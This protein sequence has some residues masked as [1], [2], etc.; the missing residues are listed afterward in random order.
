MI[1][2]LR[3][4][5]TPAE[6]GEL[7]AVPNDA[8]RWPEHRLRTELTVALARSYAGRRP[9][10]VVDLAAGNGHAAAEV[11][12]A[13]GRLYLGDY[14]GVEL[15]AVY[16]SAYGVEVLGAWRGPLEETLELVPDDAADV[17][18]LGE[19]LEHVDDPAAVLRRATVKAR[20]LVL[21]TPLDEPAGVNPEHLWR[22][23]AAGIRELLEAAAWRPTGSLLLELELP[24]APRFS[25]YRCQLW[26]AEAAR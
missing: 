23:D 18:L 2:R 17:M 6:L 10:T 4:Y 15:A 3:P 21:S 13:G 9:C 1:E 14:A 16:A 20:R 24:H 26:T 8:T 11:A 19:I 7:Y 12:G 22:W 5:P 25:P